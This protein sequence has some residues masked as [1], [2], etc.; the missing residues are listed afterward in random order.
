MASLI[1]M[2]QSTTGGERGF[3]PTPEPGCDPHPESRLGTLVTCMLA[4]GS[5][6]RGVYP[7]LQMEQLSPGANTRSKVT[8]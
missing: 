6:H 3:D 5:R 8:T 7:I 2:I 1:E 4:L